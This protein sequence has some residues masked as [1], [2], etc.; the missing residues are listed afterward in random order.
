MTGS[1][2]DRVLRSYS[3]GVRS[4]ASAS[5][6]VSDWDGATP[7]G[8]WTVQEVAGHVLAIIRYYNRLLDASQA[9]SPIRGLPRGDELAAMNARDLSGLPEPSG[10]QRLSRFH[11]LADAY[12]VRL[13]ASDWDSVLGEWS[14]LGELTISEHTGVA[15]GEW[16]VHAW[17]LARA[18]G[19]DHR[20]ENPR[21]I[22]ECQAV[23]GRVVDVEDSPDPWTAVLV[24]YGRDPGWSV[25]ADR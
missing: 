2:K 1:S 18:T 11:E 16:N 8:R 12:G 4:I 15:A 6:N 17:D 13:E 5:E 20:P 3:D 14:G 23:V 7:C 25:R 21:L 10:T 22:A 24:A 9:G 19:G